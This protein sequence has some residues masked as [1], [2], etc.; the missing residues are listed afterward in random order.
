LYYR[1]KVYVPEDIQLQRQL[2]KKHHDTPLAGHPARSKT[3]DLLSRQYYWKGMRKQVDRYV[4]N[5]AECHKSRTGRQASYAVL[6]PL[7]VPE[8]SWQDISMDFVTGLPECEG[9]DAIWLVVDRLSKMRH[10]IPCQT[11]VNAQG[12]AE[13]FMK[14]V[15]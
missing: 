1:G 15:V 3:F 4:R 12:L 10:F 8:K 2:I 14:E 7:A 11:T 9:Y 6:R 13:M 5:C